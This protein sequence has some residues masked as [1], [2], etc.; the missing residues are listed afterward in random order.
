MTAKR[1]AFLEEFKLTDEQWRM[2]LDR[3]L[4]LDLENPCIRKG[5]LFHKNELDAAA[6]E[7]AYG[8]NGEKEHTFKEVG[9]VLGVSMDRARQ[10]CEQGTRTLRVLIRR[11]KEGVSPPVISESMKQKVVAT[12]TKSDANLQ[13]ALVREKER[14]KTR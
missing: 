6:M 8:L 5:L 1:D 2:Y 4:M 11:E 9:A 10:R 7:L 14:G 12:V 3:M 13:A